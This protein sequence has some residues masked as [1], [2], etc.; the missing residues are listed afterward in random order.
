MKFP[1]D[2]NGQVF[3]TADEDILVYKEGLP[4]AAS[5][6]LCVTSA[7]PTTWHQGIG[8]NDGRVCVADPGEEPVRYLNGRPVTSAGLA[9]SS[10]LPETFLQGVGLTAGGLLSISSLV[11]SMLVD[12]EGNA[13]TTSGGEALV[14]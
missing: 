1:I 13:L 7:P 5:G 3:V 6:A 8:Y 12:S 10:D 4:F 14:R 9:T 11:L 2:E